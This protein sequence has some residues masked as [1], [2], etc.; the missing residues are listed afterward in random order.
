ME[1]FGQLAKWALSPNAN[2]RICIN[3]ISIGTRY[4]S[5]LQSYKHLGIISWY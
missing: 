3:T 5:K 2:T 1:V 4:N